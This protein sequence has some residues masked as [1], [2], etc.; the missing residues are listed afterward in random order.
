MRKEAD[1]VRAEALTDTADRTDS[2]MRQQA[3]LSL[4]V[5]GIFIVILIGMPLI[6]LYLPDLANRQIFGFSAT[7][8][9]LGIGFF[10]ITWLLSAYFIRESNRIEAELAQSQ[11]DSRQEDAP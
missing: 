1:A 5:A 7:W 4:R 6:N 2:V 3:R 11:A 10:P 9:F 8:F